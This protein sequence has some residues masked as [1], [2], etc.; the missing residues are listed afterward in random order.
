MVDTAALSNAMAMNSAT[1][2]FEPIV[3]FGWVKNVRLS[4]FMTDIP[5]A[6]PP[7]E[8][9]TQLYDEEDHGKNTLNK[10]KAI[11]KPAH[12]FI[13]IRNSYGFD[14]Q[15]LAWIPATLARISHR[16]WVS[17]ISSSIARSLRR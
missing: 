5:E 4:V 9:H 17:L 2:I 7:R 13:T 11:T 8:S 12:P 14:S 3:V 15:S 16:I 10:E 6:Q 1:G